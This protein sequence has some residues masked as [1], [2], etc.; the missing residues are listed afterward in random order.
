MAIVPVFA[1]A[2]DLPVAGQCLRQ[3]TAAAT[4][5]AARLL[6]S[7]TGWTRDVVGPDG[8]GKTRTVDSCPP[9]HEVRTTPT[10]EP[11]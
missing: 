8:D 11:A 9:C 7:F 4:P 3:S 6:A 5:S 10:E 1:L 2:C